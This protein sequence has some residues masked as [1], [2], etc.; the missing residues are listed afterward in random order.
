MNNRTLVRICT[1][2]RQN[3][4]PELESHTIDVG[5]FK[6]DKDSAMET[7]RRNKW[8]IGVNERP[9]R[10]ANVAVVEGGICHELGHVYKDSR[11]SLIG[12][13][14]LSAMYRLFPKVERR[15]EVDIDFLCC[16][17]GYG[18]QLLEYARFMKSRGFEEDGMS[19]KNLVWAVKQCQKSRE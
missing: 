1:E 10:S 6:T 4:W 14:F 3:A 17:R 2:V 15:E 16:L 9:F 19:E 8:I 5:F 11:R 7:Y 18:P 13:I 12:L